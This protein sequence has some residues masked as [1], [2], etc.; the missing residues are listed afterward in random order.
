[1]LGK[2]NTSK[3]LQVATS[4]ISQL[5]GVSQV[6]PGESE[7]VYQ[8]GLIATVQ[9]LGAE[10]PL[11]IYLSEKIYECLW[12]MRRYEN[13]KRATLIRAMASALDSHKLGG[14]VSKLEAWAT[15]ALHE[16]RIDDEFNNLL[17]KHNLTLDSLNQK[18]F[19]NCRASLENLDQM[20]ALKTKTLAGF[21]ASYEVLV[22]RKVNAER[23]RLQNALM[24]RDLGAIENKVTDESRNKSTKA[25]S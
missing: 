11:Q 6:L 18:A 15:N 4:S 19:A 14:Q 22:N 9:E 3:S 20:I 17:Q 13:Q 16:N 10:T 23:M 7:L 24:Q 2:K 12:W 1:M 8:Q 25:A 21:Q 5:V